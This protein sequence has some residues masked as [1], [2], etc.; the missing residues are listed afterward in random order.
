MANTTWK[1]LVHDAADG[2][3]IVM[4]TTD[5][6]PVGELA[7]KIKNLS[8]FVKDGDAYLISPPITVRDKTDDFGGLVIDKVRTPA[9][10]G[11]EIMFGYD[12]FIPNAGMFA[13]NGNVILTDSN[14]KI[15]RSTDGITWEFVKDLGG[16]IKLCYGGGV[17]VALTKSK[18]NYSSDGI[19]WNETTA[20]WSAYASGL[21]YG[22][23]KFIVSFVGSKEGYCSTN[24]I[25]WTKISFPISAGN[26]ASVYW[27]NTFVIYCNS[28][29]SCKDFII[30][31]NGINW[32]VYTSNEFLVF[33]YDGISMVYNGKLI[34]TIGNE[35]AYSAD[36]VNWTKKTLLQSSSDYFVYFVIR[37]ND[38]VAVSREDSTYWVR[39]STDGINWTR[40]YELE[41]IMNIFYFAN[42]TFTIN[43]NCL[44][45][46]SDLDSWTK[47]K[48]MNSKDIAYGDGKFV[49]PLSI[50]NMCKY[51]TDGVSWEDVNMPFSADWSNIAYGGGK[52]IALAYNSDKYAYSNDGI[53][54]ASGV[55]PVSG[56][57]Y[58]I[59]YGNDKF[60]AISYKNFI[61]SEN[62]TN[63][64]TSNMPTQRSWCVVTYGGGKFIALAKNSDKVAY[65][66]DGI[67]WIEISMLQSVNLISMVYG[68]GKFV[69]TNSTDKGLYSEDGINWK[70]SN[71]PK[72]VTGSYWSKIAFSD[73]RFVIIAY[74]SNKYAYSNDGINWTEAEELNYNKWQSVAEG[75][76]IIT[77]GGEGRLVS[78]LPGG[79][80]WNVLEIQ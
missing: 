29:G 10:I 17:F 34:N 7:D 31:E 15:Y 51:S 72:C 30:S 56:E 80:K 50:S 21:V 41:S 73:Q 62:G 66:E 48:K 38:V 1:Q 13:T 33:G 53:N 45:Y 16:P 20:P 55:L 11:D 47:L 14:Y 23:G 63:W 52:F 25:N 76:S 28:D 74:N 39:V 65:S 19:T 35:I 60:V 75:K 46:S 78:F 64:I 71:M 59:T 36:G 24:G 69:A 61:Y 37:N 68:N 57:W 40:K 6:I 4:G 43:G 77:F 67:N 54:W 26:Y 44:Q 8:P 58:G 2:Y 27:N 70:Q 5:K 32:T 22:G 9:G 12:G 49:A 18:I 79:Y 3:R 42:K